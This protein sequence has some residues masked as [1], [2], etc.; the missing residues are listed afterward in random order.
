MFKTD[1]RLETVRSN[2]EC[3]YN[4]YTPKS[5]NLVVRTINT[6]VSIDIPR[7]DGVISLKGSYF[8]LHFSETQN[9]APHNEYV[10]GDENSWVDWAAVALLS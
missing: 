4:R 9:A 3:D 6:H 7:E 1:E 2:F 5:L 8:D 10:Y